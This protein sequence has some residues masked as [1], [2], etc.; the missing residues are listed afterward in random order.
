[1]S[2]P[3]YRWRAL[4]TV[5][6]VAVA[7]GLL[8][9]G[10]IVQPAWYYDFADHSTFLGVPHA[11]DVI[12]NIGFT[13]VG[14][15]GIM[16]LWP[17]RSHKGLRAGWNGYLLFLIS[18][19]LTGAGSAYFH[20]APDNQ[21]LVWDRLP[22]ALACAGLLAAVRAETRRL[23]ESADDTIWFAFIAALSVAWW[24]YTGRNGAPGDLRPY[25]A[26]QALTMVLIPQWQAIGRSANADRAWFAAACGVYI[27]ARL[28]ELADHQIHEALGFLSG[29]T[30]KHLLA[31]AAA[32]VVVVRLQRRCAV[33]GG[34]RGGARSATAATAE[35]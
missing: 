29:H 10:P 25:L 24:Y 33:H 9:V 8:L 12:S 35:S 15:L 3:A 20:L 34:L 4:P 30:L 18:L 32:T 31:T 11:G 22:I 1:M 16:A 6:T 17:Q 19:I 26:L 21:R 13:V 28:C 2:I 23:P 5:T 27:V 7:V 14:A